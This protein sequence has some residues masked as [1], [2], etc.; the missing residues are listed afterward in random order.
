MI[1]A[2]QVNQRPQRLHPRDELLPAPALPLAPPGEEV[3]DPLAPQPAGPPV[4]DV[5]LHQPG[6]RGEQHHDE[7]AV[8]HARERRGRHDRL[9]RPVQQHADHRV[10][11]DQARPPRQDR[12][13][14][15][16]AEGDRRPARDVDPARLALPGQPGVAPRVCGPCLLRPRPERPPASGSPAGREASGR[17]FSSRHGSCQLTRRGARAPPP[18]SAARSRGHVIRAASLD[19]KRVRTAFA[20]GGVVASG[21]R[22]RCGGRAGSSAARPTGGAGRQAPA[23]AHLG[24]GDRRPDGRRRPG[25]HRGGERGTTSPF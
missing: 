18:L 16:A 12:Q 1:T 13:V 6:D 14:V 4:D 10:R 24:A 5:E 21:R 20:Y 22:S 8:P 23:A 19:H 2:G 15:Q 9:G 3:D 7:R 25:A 11:A 17:R